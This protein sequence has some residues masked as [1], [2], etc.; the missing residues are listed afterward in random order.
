MIEFIKTNNDSVIIK[1]GNKTYKWHGKGADKL[2]NSELYTATIIHNI[3]NRAMIDFE[4][5]LTGESMYRSEINPAASQSEEWVAD[6]L[7]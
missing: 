7:D 1:N 4:D 5:I 6:D 3:E 2:I